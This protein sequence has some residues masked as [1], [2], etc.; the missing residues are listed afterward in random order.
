[1]NFLKKL[2][3]A[4]GFIALVA[5]IFYFVFAIGNKIFVELDSDYILPSVSAFMGAFFAFL[6][7][8]TGQWFSQFYSRHRKHRN[9]LVKLEYSLN[10]YADVSNKNIG[11]LKGLD[12]RLNSLPVMSMSTFGTIQVD[13]NILLELKNIDLINDLVSFN[14]DADTGNHELHQLTVLYFEVRQDFVKGRLG[15]ERLKRT[16]TSFK[17]DLNTVLKFLES[18]EKDTK[19]MLAKVRILLERESVVDWL[20]RVTSRKQR[21]P[22]GMDLLLEKELKLLDKEFEEVE[23]ASKKKIEERLGKPEPNNV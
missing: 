12:E 6:F 9:A 10:E 14:L 1:M 17:G 7:L 16:L 3:F 20:I 5:V 22:K 21:Y 15:G 23:K 4:I 13:K 8:I 2:L 19:N 11:L 18:F